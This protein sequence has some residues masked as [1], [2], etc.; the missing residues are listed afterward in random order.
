MA[1]QP[2]APWWSAGLST[3]QGMIVPF[4]GRRRVG[5]KTSARWAAI[6]ARLLVFPPTAPWWSAG[7][8]TPQGMIVPFAGRRRVGC[9]TSARWAA[10]DRSE[11]SGVSADGS[12]VVGG[13]LNAAGYGVP[14]AGRL[15][16]GCK[17]SARWAAGIAGLMVFPP[18]APWWSARLTTPQGIRAFR[19][20]A[21]GGM[22]D[23]NTTYASLLTDGSVLEV[24]APSPPMGAILWDGA[25]TPPQGAGKPSCWIRAARAQWRCGPQRLRGRRRPAGGAVRVWQLG[26][27]PRA[28]RCEL[29]RGCG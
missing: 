27:Q 21:A 12:V 7:L 13:A 6:G 14:F 1:F 10:M 2:T 23:L 19:W 4:A 26:Q 5:C 17:T 28:C 8:S 29:R 24:R 16:V 20:T 15:L 11:A 18:T 22:E 9:K 3:P 25:T